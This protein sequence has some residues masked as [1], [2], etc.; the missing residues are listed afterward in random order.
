MALTAPELGQALDHALDRRVHLGRPDDLVA[1]QAAFR[2]VAGEP[3]LVL[4]R[5]ARDAVAGE[6]RQ[7]Q[8]GER[9]E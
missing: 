4:D 1:D 7:A 3:A 2:A 6:A 5:L 9:R 8:I